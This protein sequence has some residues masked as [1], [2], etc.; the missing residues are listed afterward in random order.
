MDELS[1]MEPAPSGVPYQGETLNITPL[2]VGQIPAFSRA[3]RPM[4]ASL[5][6]LVGS[7]P[8][9]DGASEGGGLPG[10]VRV[11]PED[12]LA[13]IA[14]HGDAFIEAAAIATR[15]EREFIAKGMLDEFVGLVLEIIRVNA[16]FFVQAVVKAEAGLRRSST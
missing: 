6:G 13:L 10:E 8:L 2:T 12:V 15:R 7:I 16:D 1:V 5:V 9:G 14:D 4:F 11:S 3:V